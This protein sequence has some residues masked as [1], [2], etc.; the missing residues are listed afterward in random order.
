MKQ[1]I[2]FPFCEK[3]GQ[4]EHKMNARI[5]NAL[6][7]QRKLIFEIRRIDHKKINAKGKVQ[8]IHLSENKKFKTH[9]NKSYY[10]KSLSRFVYA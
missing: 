7:V 8:K 10:L 1:K 3:K 5:N 4:K 2:A 6:E 9:R